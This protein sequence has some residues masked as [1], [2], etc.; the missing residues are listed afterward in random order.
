MKMDYTVQ[1]RRGWP[2]EGA[3]DRAEPIKAGSTL[4]NGDWVQKQ[5]DGTVAVSGATA[6]E[7]VG[8]V[9]QGNGDAASAVN[10]NKAV[11]LWSGF[12]ADV[13]NYDTGASY[14]PGSP[15]TVKSGKITLGVVGTD[16]IMGR[17]LDVVTAS[18]T[19]TAH[20]TIVVK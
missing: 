14:V 18:V 4:S 1:I 5:S 7:A 8:L 2:N 12:I 19:E 11:V 17:V 16:P 3:L 9:V 20:L 13:S 15:L 10:S 6:S